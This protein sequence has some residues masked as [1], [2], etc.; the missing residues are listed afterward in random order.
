MGVRKGQGGA[1]V[2]RIVSIGMRTFCISAV[3]LLATVFSN[4]EEGGCAHPE[5]SRVAQ[6]SSHCPSH[7]ELGLDSPPRA[8]HIKPAGEETIEDP[9][10]MEPDQATPPDMGRPE[11]LEMER[12][13][14]AN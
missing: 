13:S 12:E 14:S 5:L 7:E 8:K 10:D 3:S 2:E 4:L 6:E 11:V 1:T 9:Q